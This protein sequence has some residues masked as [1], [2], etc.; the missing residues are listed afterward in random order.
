MQKQRESQRRPSTSEP[1][2]VPVESKLQPAS[3]RGASGGQ[4]FFHRL[5]TAEEAQI[6]SA[7]EYGDAP[8]VNRTSFT[9]NKPGLSRIQSAKPRIEVGSADGSLSVSKANMHQAPRSKPVMEPKP[10]IDD[11]AVAAR[12]MA[13]EK[14]QAEM[15]EKIRQSRLKAKTEGAR[16]DEIVVL[17]PDHKPR[18]LVADVSPV[19]HAS[20]VTPIPTSHPPLIEHGRRAGHR[21]PSDVVTVSLSDAEFKRCVLPRRVFRRFSVVLIFRPLLWLP[22]SPG[23][24]LGKRFEGI[25]RKQSRPYDLAMKDQG[26]C[27]KCMRHRTLEN[28]PQTP[29]KPPHSVALTTNLATIALA[30]VKIVLVC[31]CRW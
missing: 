15:R 22:V 12:K 13:R 27:S 28:S 2:S 23:N 10:V 1:D 3:T 20:A 25:V 17:V 18:H 21:K 4:R 31:Q 11:E 19:N 9:E 6:A 7:R 30:R 26:L 24:K 8:V 29:L 5:S 16:N 14:A